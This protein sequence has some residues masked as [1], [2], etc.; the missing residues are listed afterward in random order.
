MNRILASSSVG[1]ALDLETVTD[2]LL[3][4]LG[5]LAGKIVSVSQWRD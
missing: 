3:G 1:S 5:A 4:I 2:S